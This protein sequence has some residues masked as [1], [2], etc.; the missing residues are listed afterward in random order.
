MLNR[1]ITESTSSAPSSNSILWKLLF[2]LVLTAVIL[3][4]FYSGIFWWQQ[5]QQLE[6]HVYRTITLASEEYDRSLQEQ[7]ATL[8]AELNW[9]IANG[10]FEE[11]LM[12][13]DADKLQNKSGHLYE[14]LSSVHSITHFYFHGTDRVNILRVHNP[15]K[16]GDIIDRFTTLEAERTGQISSGIELG[17][18]GTFTLRVV[19]PVYYNGTLIGYMELGKEIEDILS[20]VARKSDSEIG[21]FIYKDKLDRE[22][23][24]NGV[25]MLGRDGNWSYYSSQVLIYSTMDFPPEIDQ[26]VKSEKAISD[27]IEQKTIQEIE[28]DNKTWYMT[29]LPLK[30]A[31][32]TEVGY[33]VVM[34]DVTEEKR[35]FT[36]NLNVI[37]FGSALF[38]TLLFIFYFMIL[39]KTD[40]SI[41]ANQQELINSEEKFRNIFEGAVEGI[42][43]TDVESDKFR[44]VNFALCDMLG[45]REEDLLQMKANDIHP[46]NDLEKALTKSESRKRDKK[47]LLS[48]IPCLRKDGTIIY[49][50]ISIFHAVI[51]GKESRVGFYTDVTEL[52]NIEKEIQE[53]NL[54]KIAAEESSR[55]KSE[56]LANMSHELRTPLNSIIG[57]SDMLLTETFGSLN[58]KQFNYVNNISASGKH[59][60][61]LINSVLDLSKVEA[62]KM[63]LNYEEVEIIPVFKEV[64]DV[65]G[66][67]AAKK[68]IALK[69]NMSEQFPI[70]IYADRIKFK[71]ILYNLINNAIK[72]TD[73]GGHV[74]FDAS[75]KDN[76][77]YVSVTDTG[78]GISES[79]RKKLFSPF[80]Q[81]DSSTAKVHQGT[82]LGLYIVKMFV[83]LHGGEVWVTSTPGEGSTFSLCIP[84]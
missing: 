67:M 32:D 10:Q 66:P 37:I 54:A 56:F 71:Q 64:K 17:P 35:I 15:D 62:G 79:D 8:A 27:H 41:L 45:Y 76:M 7:S 80:G 23:W 9:I 18:L 22:S 24:E 52:K 2:P 72:F 77:L 13:R 74:S 49:A 14:R 44:Y 30:D 70:S 33:M 21:V 19:E 12:E 81:L 38:F 48:D 11:A 68:N 50:D 69:C 42:K 5:E 40:K 3:I 59:L 65:L 83:E 28:S 84:S 60:L 55:I 61:E 34:Q 20:S 73:S 25:K 63:E 53:A 6:D 16:S 39:H 26:V 58:K 82:G 31:S 43:V 1:E 4:S 57:F 75:I 36:T 47:V 78:I 29:F 46:E 51:D